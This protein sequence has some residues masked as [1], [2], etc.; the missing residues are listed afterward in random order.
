MV[1]QVPRRRTNGCRKGKEMERE[2]CKLL[3]SLGFPSERNARNGKSEPDILCP[4][5][6]NVHLECKADK[7]IGLGTQALYAACR[8]AKEQAERVSL[9][10]WAVLWM[11]Y[12]KGWRLT[13]YE[14]G[15]YVTVGNSVSI[16]LTLQRLNA[17]PEPGAA[18][19]CG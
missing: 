11:D 2:A 10:G 12:R 16:Q 18:G 13:W 6:V 9:I 5:L 7:S 8:Q 17:I 3:T 4:S 19:V 14:H 1:N 15:C